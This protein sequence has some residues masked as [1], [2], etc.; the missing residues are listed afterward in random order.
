[1]EGYYWG[2]LNKYDRK[3]GIFDEEMQKEHPE[4][5]RWDCCNGTGEE[6][7]CKSDKRHIE[8]I[9]SVKRTRYY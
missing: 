6:L 8:R 9:D 1:M 5:Y 7:G 3:F 4:R 2:D